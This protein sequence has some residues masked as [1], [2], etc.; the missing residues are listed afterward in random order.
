M[1]QVGAKDEI[2]INGK[3]CS[4]YSNGCVDVVLNSGKIITIPISDI[5][6][7]HPYSPPPII[8]ERKGS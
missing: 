6:T 3:I 8:D 5:N 1:L 4:V 7:I 2:S